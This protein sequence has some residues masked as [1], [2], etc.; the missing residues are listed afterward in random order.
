M[1][2][3][4]FKIFASGKK[5]IGTLLLLL[6]FPVALVAQ[7]QSR[8]TLER[9]RRRIETEIRLTNE[10]LQETR[11]SAEAGLNHLVILNA[12]ISRRE[13]LLSTLNKEIGSLNQE[14]DSQAREITRLGAELEELRSSYA[15]MIRHA[16]NTRS[17]YQRLAFIF[18][19]ENFNQALRRLRYFQEYARHRKI[20]AEVI[21]RSRQRLTAEIQ[22]LENQRAEKQVLLGEQRRLIAELAGERTEQN[23]VVRDLRRR[24]RELRER[25]R[26]QERSR[27]EL[28]RS[29][30]RVIAE[31]RRRSQEQARAEGRRV[32]PGAFALSPE[33]QVLSGNFAANKGRLPW[34]VERGV[35][36]GTFGVHPHPVLRNIQVVNNGVDFSTVPG[37]LARSVFDGRVSRVITVPGA[38]YAVIIRHGEYLTVYSNLSRVTVSNGDR[39]TTR[40]VIG[41]VATNQEEG[42]TLLHFEIWLGNQKLNPAAWIASQR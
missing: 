42:K 35:I 29:I 24:E 7:N 34:P 41:E 39:V 2:M 31:E 32:T 8:E 6:L 4:V 16:Y 12:Q 20:Q 37:A 38:F 10:M 27:Q 18:S 9:D 36:S 14:I 1:Q 25:L 21:E 28:Q 26:V 33:E 30:E 5:G 3:S 17:G 19:S 13:N 11:K 22:K 23:R 40:Q 15:R